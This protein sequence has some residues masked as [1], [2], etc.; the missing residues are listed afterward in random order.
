M[1]MTRQTLLIDCDSSQSDRSPEETLELWAKHH[2]P[3]LQR[4]ARRFGRKPDEADDDVQDTMIAAYRALAAN[5]KAQEL[6]CKAPDS[7]AVLNWLTAILYNIIRS[8]LRIKKNRPSNSRGVDFGQQPNVRQAAVDAELEQAEDLALL[9]ELISELSELRQA[10]VKLRLNE[11]TFA[12]IGEWLEISTGL[13]H[14]EYHAS[15][16]AMQGAYR[17]RAR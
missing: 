8:K 3:E 14:R 5:E 15:V 9:D 1:T 17:R 12:E 2:S 13:A 16:Q 10:I 11:L 4:R 7:P 6:A